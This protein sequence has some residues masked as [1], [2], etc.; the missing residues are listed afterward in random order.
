MAGVWTVKSNQG[1]LISN[2]VGGS[3][4]EVG[5]KIVRTKYDPFRI[6]VSRSYREL[7]EREL[8]TT[9]EHEGWRIVPLKHRRSRGSQQSGAAVQASTSSPTLPA[10]KC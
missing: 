1:E 2:V 8:K 3:P 6:E 4:R 9:L 10:T 7:F 5:R